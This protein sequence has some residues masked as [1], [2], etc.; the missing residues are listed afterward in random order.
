MGAG[1][2]GNDERRDRRREGEEEMGEGRCRR[3]RWVRG[4]WR[5][6]GG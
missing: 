6:G 4:W 3:W 2:E 5:R 1:R